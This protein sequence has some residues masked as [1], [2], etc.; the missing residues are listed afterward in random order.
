MPTIL[1][2]LVVLTALTPPIGTY[3]YRVYTSERIGRLEGPIYKLIGV[4]PTVEQTWR[5]YAACTLWFSAIGTVLLYILMRVQGHL[6]LNPVGVGGVDKYVAFNTA[7]S[8]VTNTNWQAY[9]GETTMSYFTQ[10]VGL[11]FQNFVSAAVGMAVL[12]ALI[13]GFTRARTQELGNFWRDTVRGVVYVFIPMSIV[14]AIV[15]MSQGVV[16]TFSNSVVV[17]G[18]QGFTQTIARGPVASQIAIKQLG[19]NGGG[20]FN[21]NSAHPFEG[22]GP[23][24]NFLELIAILMIPAALT[25]TFG[26]MVGN[27]RE[28]WALFAA[29]MVLFV[30][31][32]WLTVPQE[33][34]STQAMRVAGVSASAPN[35]EG[36]ELRY[37][38]DQS[39]LWAVA[40]TDASNGSVNSMHDSYKPLGGVAP[41]FNIAVGEVIWGGVGSGLYGM[42]FYVV[43]A[44]FI[45]GLMVGRTPEYLGK[46]IGAREMKLAAIAVLVP[47]LVVLALTAVAVVIPAGLNARLNAGPHGFSEILYA[48]LSQGNNN[49]SAFAGLTASGPFYAIAGGFAMLIARFVPLLAALALGGSLAKEG[50]VPVTAGT[51]PTDKPLFVGLLD[52]V[53]VI[54]GALTFFPA[55]A[56][57][58][59]VEGLLKGKLF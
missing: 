47:F 2:Y 58:A 37:G 38:T 41:M 15:L 5:R 56:L 7:T 45:G 8:F 49:G 21:V 44:V 48:F 22:A 46:K 29:M 32:L 31:G 42:I 13:R 16:Q 10:M 24:G 57:G 1:V 17:H 39:A 36:K 3:M 34:T 27:V 52:G 23:F 54:I 43:I 51:L 35:L 4:D 9:G 33:R 14:F 59:I 50:T 26:K 30:A 6:P 19:T 40:T 28:G 18:I 25:Y 12:I 11:T 20:F 53:V 55:L